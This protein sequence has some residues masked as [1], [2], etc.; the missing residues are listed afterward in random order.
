MLFVAKGSYCC[1]QKQSPINTCVTAFRECVRFGFEFGKFDFGCNHVH[2]QMNIPKRHSLLD[3]KIILK[4]KS[5]RGKFERYPE[6]QKLYPCGSF[7]NGDERRGS[8]GVINLEE[9]VTYIWV[10]SIII[11]WKLWTMHNVDRMRYRRVGMRHDRS[12]YRRHRAY[13]G[14]DGEKG[15]IGVKPLFHLIIPWLFCFTWWGKSPWHLVSKQ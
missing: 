3:T 7:W 8:T 11:L 12:P 6:F 13:R 14:S 2:F 10:N 4:S 1:F 5:S 9:S 15:V